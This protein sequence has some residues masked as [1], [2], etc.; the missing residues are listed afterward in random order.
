MTGTD[1]CRDLVVLVADADMREA[2]GSLIRRHKSFR[3]REISHQVYVHPGRDP[4]CLR[5]ASE[6][7]R[8][9]SNRFLHALV[10]FDL[11]GC[12]REQ[13]GRAGLENEVEQELHRDGWQERARAIVINPE[14][15]AWLWSPSPHVARTLGWTETKP[16]LRPWLSEEGYWRE[17]APKPDRPKEAMLATLREVRKPRSASVFAALGRKVGVSR[18]SDP[19]FGKLVAT[20]RDW[21][22]V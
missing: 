20:L 15:E 13:A 4:G 2:M 9:F 10:L 17:E 18:C 22:G 7:L 12:G 3:I 1:T 14:L 19:A 21:F 6:F 8:P 11:E 16:A 5:R